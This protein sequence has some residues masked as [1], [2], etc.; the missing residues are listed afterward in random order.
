MK[1]TSGQA[2]LM[3]VLRCYSELVEVWPDATEAKL[4]REAA[5]THSRAAGQ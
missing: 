3:S 2:S 1:P 5:N 4:T